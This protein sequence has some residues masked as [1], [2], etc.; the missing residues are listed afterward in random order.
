MDFKIV[1][2]SHVWEDLSKNDKIR[3]M[4]LFTLDDGGYRIHY[5]EVDHLNFREVLTEF[6]TMAR[7]MRTSQ[8][9]FFLDAKYRWDPDSPDGKPQPKRPLDDFDS[10]VMVLQYIFKP[11]F[12]IPILTFV[13]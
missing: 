2:L 3:P 4:A 8:F 13:E 10:S 6:G 7:S 1:G 5:P 9:C 12:V 11:G